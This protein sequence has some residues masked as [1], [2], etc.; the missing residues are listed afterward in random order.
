MNVRARTV[1]SDNPSCHTLRQ[2]SERCEEDEEPGQL[3]LAGGCRIFHLDPYSVLCSA[4][5]PPLRCTRHRGLASTHTDKALS[6]EHQDQPGM[7]KSSARASLH[8]WAGEG[9]T[10]PVPAA[11]SPWPGPPPALSTPTP[12]GRSSHQQTSPL[13][14]GS[15]LPA[16][17]GRGREP[18]PQ[19]LGPLLFSPLGPSHR[20]EHCGRGARGRCYRKRIPLLATPLWYGSR[21]FHNILGQVRS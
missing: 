17:Q 5:S 20:E 14:V 13:S 7:S 1:T 10:P 2:S 16:V 15:Q 11:K 12:S 18:L 3:A 6:R 19:P 4:P 9:A 8:A 21:I